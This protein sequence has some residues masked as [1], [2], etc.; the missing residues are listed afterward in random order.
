MPSFRKIVSLPRD[1]FPRAFWA[2]FERYRRCR[3]GQ[4]LTSNRRYDTIA[5]SSTIDGH[6]QQLRRFASAMVRIGRPAQEI[7]GLPSLFDSP[8][9]ENAIQSERDRFGGPRPSLEELAATLVA[10]ARRYLELPGER[11]DEIAR[12]K[13]RLKCRTRGFTEKNRE[14]L[15]PFRDPRNQTAFLFFGDRMLKLAPKATSPGRAAL[16]VQTALMH[17]ILLVAPMRMENLTELHIHRSF[18]FA[19][20]GRKGKATI[21]VPTGEVK[22]GVDLEFELPAPTTELLRRY[23]DRSRP[24][25][26]KGED[27]GWLFPGERRDLPKHQVSLSAQLSKTLRRHTGLVVNPHL[28][29]HIAAYFYLEAHP[30][31]Y[32]TVRRLLGHTSLETTTLFYADIDSVMASRRYAEHILERR[33]I[34][35]PTR[36]KRAEAGA[37]KGQA[38]LKGKNAKPSAVADRR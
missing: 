31:D 12:I 22:N 9:F 29:R 10:I 30:G 35:E 16:L 5:R 26:L 1:S 2:D 33:L 23:L 7:A 17:E 37:G 32:E 28:Y 13:G 20:P 25:L 34:A 6:E 36:D 27:D 3:L 8:W 24:A 14:R 11:V 38:G 19:G 21:V 18:R 15:R 4:D